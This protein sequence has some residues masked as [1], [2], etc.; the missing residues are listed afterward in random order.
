VKQFYVPIVM[1]GALILLE[2]IAMDAKWRWLIE[3]ILLLSIFTLFLSYRNKINK[4]D[5]NPQLI[6]PEETNLESGSKIL[7]E[8]S[9]ILG[10]EIRTINDDI[11][12]V[13]QLISQAIVELAD[14]FNK[15]SEITKQ[16]DNL[17]S[18]VIEKTGEDSSGTRTS[19]R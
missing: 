13:K 5:L 12:R 6:Q 3:A 18:D 8:I 11:S 16:Q 9:E 2:I 14:G 4:T 7:I 15:I 10:N 19:Y 1:T 17:I